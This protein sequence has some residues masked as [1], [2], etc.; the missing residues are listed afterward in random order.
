MAVETRMSNKG[1]TT[2]GKW[3][4]MRRGFPVAGCRPILAAFLMVLM[5]FLWGTDEHI[6]GA[7]MDYYPGT[8]FEVLE[9]GTI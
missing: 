9:N 3:R 5:A 1:I 6:P 4:T 2:M 7:V 8:V